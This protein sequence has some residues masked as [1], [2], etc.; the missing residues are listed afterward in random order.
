[1][2][3]GVDSDLDVEV[4]DPEIGSDDDL[5][6]T[7]AKSEAMMEGLSGRAKHKLR[8]QLKKQTK[9]R[10][11]ALK[12]LR[13]KQSKDGME[14]ASERRHLTDKIKL[15]KRQALALIKPKEAAEEIRA[16]QAATHDMIDA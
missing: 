13:R 4:G 10:L 12:G 1:M 5:E 11:S 7:M 14:R 8:I 9:G 3:D 2:M 16:A 6:Q 15:V